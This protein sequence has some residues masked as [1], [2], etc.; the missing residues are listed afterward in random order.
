M[1]QRFLRT[2]MAIALGV[3]FVILGAQN[4]ATAN[5]T[6]DN[7]V[8]PIAPGAY[9]DLP[10]FTGN[11]L[12]DW[13]N[14][15]PG[16]VKTP[17][18]LKSSLL[19]DGS[20]FRFVFATAQNPVPSAIIT[21]TVMTDRQDYHPGEVV[22][23][24]G[25][26]FEPGETISLRVVH[27]YGDGDDDTSP[28]HQPW[29]VS[30]DLNGD[31]QSTW[32]VPADEDEAGATLRLTATGLTSGLQ[33][34][35]IFTDSAPSFAPKVDYTA[36][37]TPSSVAVGDFN[38]DGK[39]DL[40]VVNQG[41]NTVSVL[42]NNINGT[43]LAKVDYATSGSAAAVAVGDFNGDGKPDLA[44]ASLNN[45]VNV[46]IN[47]GTGTFAAKVDYA[48]GGAPNSIAVGDFNGDGKPDLAMATQNGNT[49]AV[50][51]N[52]GTGTFAAA[53]GY[54]VGTNP[55]AV[56]V[57]DFNADGKPDLALV[58]SDSKLSV[59][60]NNGNGTF[61]T[62]TIYD[63]GNNPKGVTAADL[64]ADGFPDIAV[65]NEGGNSVSVLLNN[66]NGTFAAK[67]DYAASNGP[68]FSLA[69]GD[70]DGDG[71][72]DLAVPGRFAN[73]L[74]VFTNNGAGIFAPKVILSTVIN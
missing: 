40:A 1:I 61:A 37:S 39:P 33:A 24:S 46:L 43:F 41:S 3:G 63:T 5:L 70:F 71:K 64:N 28:A 55:R 73:R 50:L 54:P 49:A 44:V 20:D 48:T 17:G 7:S 34:V 21:A 8:S 68:G 62:R 9:S 58:S 26:G 66:G 23:I 56:A 60:N 30:A 16:K 32:L 4:A 53:V 31:F 19:P 29:Y 38:A 72:P 18:M 57:A 25:T 74:D 22:N 52:N 69:V 10:V 27:A 11:N 45:V 36:G 14:S 6:T 35:T 67:V 12:M 59:L 65:A 15:V 47:N 2:F 51:I 42:L 13:L